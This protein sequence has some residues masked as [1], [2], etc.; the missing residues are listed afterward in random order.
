MIQLRNSAVLETPITIPAPGADVEFDTLIHQT[1]TCIRFT[2]SGLELP[3]PGMYNT[4]CAV[5]LQNGETTESTVS[6]E[7]TANGEYVPGAVVTG[8]T[9]PGQQTTLVLPWAVRVIQGPDGLAR[10]G[11]R[12]VGD[13]CDLC[14]A[15]AQAWRMV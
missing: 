10:I 6:L 3:T 8:T 14:N 1:N 4:I 12:L 7:L 15:F 9:T 2:G 13:E 11:W 5:V